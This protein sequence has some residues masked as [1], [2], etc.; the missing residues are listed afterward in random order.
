M[1]FVYRDWTIV[2]ST[3]LGKVVSVQ[4]LCVPVEK[5]DMQLTMGEK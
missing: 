1:D 3:R 2:F 4:G 5:N